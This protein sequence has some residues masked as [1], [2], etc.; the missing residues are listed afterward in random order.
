[1]ICNFL[2][3]L[4]RSTTERHWILSQHENYSR[5]RLKLC[6]NYH[7]D[8]HQNASNLRDNAGK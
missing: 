4:F 8:N 6:P 3:L 2:F 7:F 1:M 5:M